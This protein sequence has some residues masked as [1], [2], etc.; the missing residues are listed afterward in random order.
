MKP[1]K[2]L[3]FISSAFILLAVIGWILPAKG[4]AFGTVTL[5]FPSP[6]ELFAEA[7]EQE[8]V[9]VD[10]NLAR[11]ELSSQAVGLHSMLDS[12]KFY[13][14]F[15]T[16]DVS[17]IHF[18]NGD[19]TYFDSL[20]SALAKASDSRTVRVLH[21]GDSQ[22]EMDRI[23]STFRQSLQ[24]RYGGMGAGILP[25]VQTIPTF[26][27]S[28]SSSGLS[29]YVCYGDSTQ[30][31]APHRRYGLLA[32]CAQANG[33]STFTAR[34][35]SGK[36][37]QPLARKYQKVTL[38]V[39]NSQAGF[40]ATCKGVKRSLPNAVRGVSLLQWEFADSLTSLS[41]TMNGSADVY[42]IALEGKNGV[43]VTNV[44]MRGCSGTIF[45]R[46]DSA[47]LGQCYRKMAVDLIIMQY[48][49]NM[50]PSISSDKA[51]S[52]YMAA[53][54]KQL[55][56]VRKLYPKARI[57]FIG[58]SDMSKRVNGKLQTYPF[59]PKLNE[60]L[61]QTVLAHNA[62]YWDMFSVMGGENSMIQWVSHQPAWAGPDYIHFTEAGAEQIAKVLSKSFQTH[63]DFYF[64][65]S[66]C[67]ADLVKQFMESGIE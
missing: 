12:L 44:P 5:R 57:L 47:I 36:R 23:T 43:S 39:G 27:V 62:A 25:P 31:R 51:V 3:L 16:K 49:G 9:D 10:E 67:H 56:Y 46:I 52:N 54:A 17:R 4:L 58:P 19:Y 66:R 60:A 65:R 8:T 37:V 40:S 48:G 45:T 7:K 32:T 11:L 26:T 14:R 15:T 6:G 64:L 38:L 50:M 55:D 33:V 18:P 61:R 24:A 59:L 13:K 42:G 35:S 53:I 29:R 1:S 28:Q 30:P 63:A 22:I 21:Y 2:I 41:L 34:A 20:F